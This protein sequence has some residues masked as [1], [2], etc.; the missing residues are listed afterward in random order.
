MQMPE[1]GRKTWPLPS[2]LDNPVDSLGFFSDAGGAK[3]GT[4]SHRYKGLQ[5]IFLSMAAILFFHT[6][7]VDFNDRPLC[8]SKV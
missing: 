2:N 7:M 1:F 6:D 5:A 4:N 8:S 3:F